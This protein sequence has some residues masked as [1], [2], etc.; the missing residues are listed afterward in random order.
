MKSAAAKLILIPASLSL[1]ATADLAGDWNL[2]EGAGATIEQISRTASDPLR[3]G[4]TWSTDTPGPASTASL[5]FDGSNS[6]NYATSARLGLNRNTTDL[7]IHGTGSKTIIAWI[8]TTQA[9][10]RYFWGWSPGNGLIP[11]GDLRLGI[12]NS[13]KLRFE[14]SNGYTRYDG[15]IPSLVC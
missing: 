9:E 10:K 14:V 15:F 13:G 2:E 12:E 11:G 5:H 7:S 8:K 4:V 3:T 1:Q 6:G